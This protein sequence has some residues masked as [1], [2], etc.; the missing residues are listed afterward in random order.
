MTESIRNLDH[1]SLRAWATLETESYDGWLLRYGRGYTGRANSVQ[2][3]DGSSLPLDEKIAYCEAWYADRNLPCVFR[4]N[5]AMQP[6]DLDEQ[7][8]QRGYRR[9]NETSVQ[10]VALDSTNPV[11]DSRFRYD[12]SVSDTWLSAWAIWNDVPEQHFDTAKEMLGTDNKTRKCFAWIDDIAVG[13]AVVDGDYSGLFDIVVDPSARRQGAGKALVS[14]L[15][16]W[17]KEQGAREVYLQ[18][19]ASNVPAVQLY[20]T[21]GFVEHYRYWYRRKQE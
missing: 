21:L 3:L 10:T 7:L 9:Y 20:D 12:E 11:M 15:M 16:A 6:P 1:I 19:V 14:G 13:L 8:E 5:P 2:S 17:S 18:V 4:L